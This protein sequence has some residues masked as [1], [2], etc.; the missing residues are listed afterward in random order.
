MKDKVGV[1]DQAP[2]P[3]H[4]QVYSPPKLVSYGK[5]QRITAGG[6]GTQMDGRRNAHNI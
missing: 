2:A 6:Q 1:N 3:V 5:V 4:K